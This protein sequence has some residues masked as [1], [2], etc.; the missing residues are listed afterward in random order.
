MTY[1]H[2][3]FTLKKIN[4]QIKVL[5]GQKETEICSKFNSESEV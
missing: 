1:L 3:T 5:V 2:F 4:F